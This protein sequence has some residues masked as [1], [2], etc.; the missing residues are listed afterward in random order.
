MSYWTKRR[1]E[2]DFVT[3]VSLVVAVVVGFLC[4]LGGHSNGHEQGVR[5]GIAGVYVIDTLSDGTTVVV[6]KKGADDG[7]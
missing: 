7:K 1:G 6:K 5:D 4:Y 3:F 2:A